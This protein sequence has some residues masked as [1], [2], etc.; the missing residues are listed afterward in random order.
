MATED[1]T[2]GQPAPA[3]FPNAHS[4]T[5]VM[6]CP[7]CG[8][9][10]P[11]QARFCGV[12]GRQLTL[13]VERP[14][15]DVG[16]PQSRTP[17]NSLSD[18]TPHVLPVSRPTAIVFLSYS[19]LDR[20]FVLRL[21]TDL[22]AQGIHIWIDQDGLQPGTPDWEEAVRCAIREADALVLAASP[23][24]RQ[25]R[26]VKDELEVASM[27]QRPIYP[28]W[29]SGEQW[30][31]SVPL[32]RGS[33]QYIDARGTAYASGVHHLAEVLL[34][35]PAR[36]SALL[37]ALNGNL[38]PPF[39]PRNPY[40]GLFAFSTQDAQ[41]FFGREQ[42]IQETIQE[43]N[44]LLSSEQTGSG[45]PRLMALVG[46]SGSGKSSVVMAGV[47]PHL[48]RGALPGS[49]QWIYLKPLIP[50]PHPLEALALTFA[51]HF[52][53][54]ELR[55]ILA[56]LEDE[57][58]R[59]LHLLAAALTPH[60]GIKVVLFVDQFEEL[61][62]QTR[63][64]KERK[65]FID[66]L[67][68]AATERHNSLFVLLTLR[69]D[70]Y[71][72]PA[73][74][75]ELARLLQDHHRLV[76]SMDVKDLRSVIE[77]PARLPDVQVQFQGDLVGDMLFEVQGQAS[78]LPLLQFTLEQL[79]QRR[80]GHLL[81]EQAYRE[82]GGIKGALSRRAEETYQNLPSDAHR[83]VAHDVFLR[84]VVPGE[85]GQA[86]TKRRTLLSEFEQADPVQAQLVQ[87]TLETFINARF[88][89]TNQIGGTTTIEVSHEALIQ[90]WKR[91]TEWLTEAHNDIQLQQ[92]LSS[93]VTEWERR[94]RPG[95]QLYRGT[96]L[97][98]AQAWASRNRP[99]KQ[100]IAFL[101]ASTH[102]RIQSLVIRTVVA[103][104]LLSAIFTGSFY[105]LTRPPDPT[106]VTTLQDNVNGS[107]RYCVNN[108]PSGSTITFAPG[109]Q[110][111]IR[112]T[113]GDLVVQAKRHLTLRGDPGANRITI[114]GGTD[115]RIHVTQGSRLDIYNLSFK[116][117]QVAVIGFFDNE[118]TMTLTDSLVSGMKNTYGVDG[119][120]IE[121]GH[122]A[123]LI[124][125]HSILSDN[126]AIGTASY[127]SGG[128]INND[129]NLT[130]IDS[131]LQ[132]NQ[133]TSQQS[134]SVGGAIKNWTTGSLKI[135]NSTFS[136][137][138][139]SSEG[140]YARG[141]G[142]DSE[143][144]TLTVMNST[145]SINR[146]ISSNGTSLGGGIFNYQLGTVT[147]TNSTFSGNTSSSTSPPGN[148]YD[149]EGGGISNY[150][151]LIV[152]SS[153]FAKNMV[154]GSGSLGGGISNS[155]SVVVTASIFAYNSSID[156][157]ANGYSAGGGIDNG[158]KLT[159]INST[160]EYNIAKA[161]EVIGGAIENETKS[162]LAVADST[163]AYNSATG[164]GSDSYSS[165]GGIDNHGNSVVMRFSTIYDNAAG[166]GGGIW[167]YPNQN[168][169]L[170]LGTSIIAAN[171]ATVGADISGALTSN[172]Y[173]L[174]GNLAGARGLDS[175]R[176][177]QVVLTALKINPT[178]ARNGG[179]T[180]TLALLPRSLAIDAV[181]GQFCSV[182]LTDALGHTAVITKDQRGD[183]R[184]DQAENECDIGA[185]ESSY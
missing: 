8:N 147:V 178:L 84:L 24:S 60:S 124:I 107:L 71:D 181:P 134:Y 29:A 104:L 157:G 145:F 182:T 128:A 69:A 58:A 47:L 20:D 72:R 152:T 22:Q 169:W 19:H 57:D 40:K 25:S 30:I 167:T 88:L 12:C 176:D 26:V 133:A 61:F 127:A 59:G 129:G 49:Q 66:L 150:G 102:L 91:L 161:N 132:G 63:D 65:R 21:Q 32:G 34:S 151:K 185:Y 17:L 81:T 78:I 106:V 86:A 14:Q 170:N 155:G 174:I 80:H 76:L 46:P 168:T 87:Q 166:E 98:E 9:P 5:P 119:G 38:G 117:S 94:K 33:I 36:G 171:S 154:S 50:G 153:S 110:G 13:T 28:V 53:A 121:N 56:D 160:F 96:L 90:E 83:Q 123:T 4:T 51:P 142:I 120:A 148:Y 131:T 67:L 79:F 15:E 99:N 156:T 164:T 77:G 89:T 179:P 165:G 135:I 163:F 143:G 183:S 16:T 111:T 39:E 149:A 113:G 159:V 73:Q 62:T 68:T 172:G 55:S 37:T 54:R 141:G 130:V 118:G 180:P 105:L 43:C 126:I 173:N 74:Y 18:S 52:P 1:Q 45:S 35:L 27:Y 3:P 158:N 138:T 101:Q 6:R 95:D 146:A 7:E 42:L 92:S 11:A 144:G 85:P 139:A 177:R 100:E 116:D 93:A 31:E 103:L 48:Q 97:K 137:N 108:A 75:P 44:S 184:P 140:D 2:V 82:I 23:N 122:G 175:S 64:E 162:S 70:F 109:L 125:S 112:L 10:L 41:D 136:G 114:S 115:A